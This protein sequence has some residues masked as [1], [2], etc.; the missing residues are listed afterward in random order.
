MT[1]LDRLSDRLASRVFIEK[2][3]RGILFGGNIHRAYRGAFKRC[4]ACSKP[5][6]TTK[7]S[8]FPICAKCNLRK[9]FYVHYYCP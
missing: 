5:K 2:P 6:R 8:H 7:S 9:S 1:H 4:V 3:N